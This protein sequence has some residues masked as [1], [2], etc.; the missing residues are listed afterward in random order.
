MVLILHREFKDFYND[1]FLG[2][3]QFYFPQNS[4][5]TKPNDLVILASD[6]T[7]FNKKERLADPQNEAYLKAK[8]L[9]TKFSDDQL[10]EV[11][12][13]GQAFEEI[14]ATRHK[15]ITYSFLFDNNSKSVLVDPTELSEEDQKGK[16]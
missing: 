10:R 2:Y 9:R 4:G 5:I 15:R 8:N 7:Q 6:M 16:K 14:Q 12:S 13:V 11:I 3:D 1:F